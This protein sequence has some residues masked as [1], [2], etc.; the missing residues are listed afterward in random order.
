[1]RMRHGIV[2]VNSIAEVIYSRTSYTDRFISRN[3]KGLPCL[4]AGQAE[5]SKEM[6]K[7]KTYKENILY[8]L[9]RFGSITDVKARDIYGTTR[10]SEY[11]RQ[12]RGEGYDITTEWRNGRNRYG[13][14][15]RF[16]VYVYGGK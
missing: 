10:C 14:K 6:A 2:S 7:G 1:M 13:R 3:H 5:R 12:L 4:V 11:I 8:H 16:G 9:Q 15:T